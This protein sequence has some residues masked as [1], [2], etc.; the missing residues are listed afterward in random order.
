MTLNL[1]YK[2]Y[3]ISFSSG[4]KIKCSKIRVMG[5]LKSNYLL[6]WQTIMPMKKSS[7]ATKSNRVRAFLDHS[8]GL[9]PWSISQHMTNEFLIH[10]SRWCVH[11]RK[12]V[13]LPHLHTQLSLLPLQNQIWSWF[14][15]SLVC[16]N[17]LLHIIYIIYQALS[18]KRN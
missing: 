2:V 5:D 13:A 15:H 17:K 18:M 6:G 11:G 10:L 4:L 1:A 12:T 7:K 8:L 14:S 16:P 9:F 3:I